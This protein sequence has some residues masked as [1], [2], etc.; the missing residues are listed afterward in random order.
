MKEATGEANMTVVTVILIAVVVAV[1][2][3]I[4][5]SMMTTTERKSCC[6]NDGG[7]WKDNGCSNGNSYSKGCSEVE[8][9]GTPAPAVVPK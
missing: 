2:T 1:A 9:S 3:P 4:V 8:D 7:T 5:N 6:M